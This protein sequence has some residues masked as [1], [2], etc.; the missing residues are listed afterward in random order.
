MNIE[1]LHIGMPVRHP[2][3]GTGKVVAITQHTC[4]IAFDDGNKRTV[5]PTGSGLAPAEAEIDVKGLTIPLKQ[6]VADV[7]R[8]VVDKLGLEDPKATVKGLGARWS[9]G[10]LIVKPRDESLQSKEIPIETFFHKIVMMRNQLR[11]LEQKINSNNELSDADKVE[12][13]QYITRCYGSMTTFN[14]LFADKGDQ[15][16]GSGG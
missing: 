12:L 1:T 6:F 13:Q 2:A 5:S 7:T 14:I 10:Q 16:S 3:Y 15:F 11:V 8:Q 9:G 4:D